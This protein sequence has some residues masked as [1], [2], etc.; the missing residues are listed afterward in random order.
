MADSAQGATGAHSLLQPAYLLHRR[1]YSGTSLLVELLGR[2]MGRFPAIAKGAQ[3]KR[4]GRS[5]LLQ[6]FVPL[7]VGWSGGGEVKTVTR[8]EPEGSAPGLQG[9]VLYCGFYLNEL[10]MRLLGRQD[11]CPGLFDAYAGA[12]RDLA[13]DPEPGLALRR[14]EVTLLNELGYGLELTTD[15]ESGVAVSADKHY[16]YRIETGPLAVMGEP[17]GDAVS[18]RTLLGLAGLAPMDEQARREARGLMRR[19]LAHYL[20]GRALKSRELFTKHS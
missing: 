7:V 12:L 3:S 16:R 9:R 18:G 4:D 13:R 8:V 11:P 6:P 14:F 17:P 19:V 1:A 10:L 2:E 20:G 15:A 5:A